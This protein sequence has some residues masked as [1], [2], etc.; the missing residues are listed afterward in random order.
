MAD[1][2]GDAAGI[3]A[4]APFGLRSQYLAGGVNTGR[5]WT[6]WGPEASYVTSYARESFDHGL[7]PVFDYYMLLHSSPGMGDDE[8]ERDFTNLNNVETMAAY[9]ADLRLFLERAGALGPGPLVLH[10]EPDL[11][12]FMQR[13]ALFDNG[14][15]VPAKVAATGAEGLAGL[16]D[17]V[18][19][20]ARA[21]IALRDRYAPNVL[22]AYHLSAWG[23]GQEMISTDP[24]GAR[25]GLLAKSAAAFY[26]SL[27]ADFDIVF[28]D[29]S[30]RDAAFRERHFGD[31]A[32]WW[33]A[34][35]YER[36]VAFLAGFVAAVEKRVVL[37]QTPLGNTR[38]RAQDN[39][40][41]HYQDNHV[42]WLLD[43]R[44][45]AHMLEYAKAGVVAAIFGGGAAGTTC[46]CDAMNDG[47]T[48]PPAINGNGRLSLSADDDGGFFRA[49]A[50]A[51]YAAGPLLLPGGSSA[52]AASTPGRGDECVVSADREFRLCP[53]RR[54][55]LSQSRR[56]P[57]ARLSVRIHGAPGGAMTA[58]AYSATFQR[59]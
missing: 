59:M 34:E 41:G 53:R 15:R 23:T 14:A 1:P 12:G 21:I 28:T 6:S 7:I 13:R 11:W 17:T 50:G 33:T 37:W 47:V 22:V 55:R 20:F 2:L 46:A 32:A 19:G 8:A 9:Y 24:D 25:V 52:P 30:D 49:L 39:S 4:T 36:H 54:G 16:P 43:D 3:R 44:P 42:E 48:D 18:A 56:A 57:S 5:G 35:D 27:G 29:T 45:R 10:L 38:M 58:R 51:Y 26:R 40:W 31:A